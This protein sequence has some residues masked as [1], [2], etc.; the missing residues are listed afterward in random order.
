MLSGWLYNFALWIKFAASQNKDQNYQ[1]DEQLLKLTQFEH[2]RLDSM[3]LS[4]GADHCIN[5]FLHSV[6]FPIFSLLCSVW[7]A[8]LFANYI[9]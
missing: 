5:V 9:L 2:M 7:V 1:S 6:P 4:S 3:L 8:S